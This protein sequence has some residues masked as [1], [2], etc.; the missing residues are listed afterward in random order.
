M[1]LETDK[2]VVEVPSTVSGV[3]R[4]IKVKEGQKVKVGEVIFTLEGGAG[5]SGGTPRK[6]EPVEHMS[7]QQ[8]ARLAFQLAMRAEGKTEEQALPPDRPQARRRRSA[9]PCNWAR[10]PARTAIPFR[11]RRTCAVWRAKSE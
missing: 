1:E 10:L 5:R 9:C 3:V 4:E 2:A 11:R 7:G 8:G 6:H